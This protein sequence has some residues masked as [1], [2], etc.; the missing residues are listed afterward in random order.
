MLRIYCTTIRW[1]DGSLEP[2]WM[3]YGV[4]IAV[5]ESSKRTGT[6]R[7]RD[8]VP[9]LLGTVDPKL[10]LFRHMQVSPTR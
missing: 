2:K 1:S 5:K 7:N 9:G 8:L 3:K 10:H 6:G 4:L